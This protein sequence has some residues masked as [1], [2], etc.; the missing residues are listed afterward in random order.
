MISSRDILETIQMIHEEHL[1]IRTITMGISLL[2]CASENIDTLCTRIYDKITKNAERLVR[3][4]EEIER[5]LGI[6]IINKRISVTPISLVAA[7]CRAS[8]FV[9]VAQALDRAAQTVGVNF[10]GGFSALVHKGYTQGDRTLIAS[11]PEALASTQVVCSSVNVATTKAGIN[12][13]AVAEMGRVIKK[14]AYLTKDEG[15]IGCAKLVVF[16][17][18]PEDN[19]FMAGAFHGVGEPET[20]INVGVSGP[21]VVRAA[22]ERAGDCDLATLAEIIKRTAFKITRVG[23]LVANEASARLGVPFGIV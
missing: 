5:D 12:M 23:Q 6:P 8:S 15:S 1:D 4:G 21:G 3:T 10:L 2:D 17:N 7:A 13:D 19:P 20:V 18:V 22:V 9:P 11:I 14:T 16:S